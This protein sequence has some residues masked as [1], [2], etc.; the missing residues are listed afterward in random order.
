MWKLSRLLVCS[1]LALG[2]VVVLPMAE[3]QANAAT[4]SSATRVNDARGQ[5]VVTP[6]EANE[7]QGFAEREEAAQSLENFHG[8]DLVI[9]IGGT[10][11]AV[12]LVVV[13]I[14]LLIMR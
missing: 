7:L 13:L 12:V 2:L 6:A 4:A 14:V 11:L 3:S 8:G 10:T 5:L 9:V 1:L